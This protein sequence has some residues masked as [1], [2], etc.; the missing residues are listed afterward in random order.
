MQ[1]AATFVEYFVSGSGG[2]AWLAILLGI[3]RSEVSNLEPAHLTLLLP[4][5]YILGMFIDGA[6]SIAV[7]PLKG[8][9]RSDQPLADLRKRLTKQRNVKGRSETPS[10]SSEN[11]E[12]GSRRDVPFIVLHSPD[13]A[14]ELQARSSRDR[15]ARG[16][17]LNS[18]LVMVIAG[19]SP[20]RTRELLGPARLGISQT[21]IVLSAAAIAIVAF[22]MWWH[23]EYYTESFRRNAVTAIDEELERAS[24]VAANRTK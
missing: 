15:I 16:A 10:L 22:A 12:G 14:R 1:F 20:E 24:N 3:T 2:L 18:L 7:K 5:V 4:A 17:W 23:F 8:L 6:V 13:L 11:S 19:L 21:T 9:A